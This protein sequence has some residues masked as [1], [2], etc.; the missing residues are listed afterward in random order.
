[1]QAT[2]SYEARTGL[3][4]ML[5]VG[6]GISLCATPAMA[7]DLWVDASAGAG[8][9]GSMGNPFQ[10]INEGLDAAMPSDT[11]HVLPGIYDAVR[12]VRNGEPDQW[13]TVAAEMPREAVVESDGTALEVAHDYHRFEGLVFDSGYGSGDGVEGGSTGLEL[14][15]VEVRRTR[16]DCVDLRSSS[17]VSIEASEIHHCVAQFDP[18]NNADAHG[19]TGDSLFGLTIRDCEIYLVTGDALQVSP[20]R[21]PWDDVLVERTRMWSGALDEAANGWGAGDIIG[22]NAFDSKVGDGLNGGGANPQVT[23]TDVVAYG[24]RGSI[25]NQ[26]AF[27]VKE[28]VDFLLD[29]ATIYDSEIAF[30]LRFPAVV[31]IHNAVVY[32]VDLGFRLEDGLDGLNVRNTTLGGEIGALIDDAGGAPQSPTFANVLFLADSVPAPADATPSNMAV[33]GSV[34]VD[35]ASHDYHLLMGAMPMDA[36]EALAEV[37]VDR[38]GVPR[39]FGPAYDIG[40][41]EWTDEPPPGG[42][43]G[44]GGLD[45]SGGE[46]GSGGGSEGNTGGPGEGSPTAGTGATAGE[47]S[48]GAGDDDGGGGCGCRAGAPPASTVLLGLM[49]AGRVRR[50]RR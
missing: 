12:T 33:D 17:E 34:F 29:R 7:A 43:T 19:V 4:G 32:D 13:I 18:G 47:T 36:G 37:A 26:G 5:A 2:R 35:S 39:P 42:S 14:V 38:D 31:T 24:W 1:M 20:S 23:F 28:D 6:L 40:A 48:A 45:E 30:R 50:R 8:G 9:D 44:S 3:G 21:D 27:N 10:T 46:A 11:V 22:E 16:G 25:S 15:D 49:L 41:Y